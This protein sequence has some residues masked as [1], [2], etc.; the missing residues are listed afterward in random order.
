MYTCS[1]VRTGYT[2]YV[3]KVIDN[4]MCNADVC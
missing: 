1:N 3:Y 4:T 2:P